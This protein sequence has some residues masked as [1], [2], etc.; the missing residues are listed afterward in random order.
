MEAPCEKPATMARSGS[1][2]KSL[3]TRLA[4]ESTSRLVCSPSSQ[5]K[6]CSV[7]GWEDWTAASR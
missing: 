7:T 3:V 1:Y 5:Q 2:G 4:I 6:L